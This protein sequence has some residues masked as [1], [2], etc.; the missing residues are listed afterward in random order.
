MRRYRRC[1]DVAFAKRLVQE[2]DPLHPVVYGQ[3]HIEPVAD[4]CVYLALRDGGEGCHGIVEVHDLSL[5]EFLR[6][7]GRLGRV[8]RDS[9]LDVWLV[10][11]V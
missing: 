9:Y 5:G 6:H 3:L 7:D 10:E 11:L 1:G 4:E 2:S 8:R